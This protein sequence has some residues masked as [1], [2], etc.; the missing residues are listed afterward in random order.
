MTQFVTGYI[1][2][3]VCMYVAVPQVHVVPVNWYHLHGNTGLS[4]SKDQ[5]VELNDI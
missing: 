2:V 4:K 1:N 3:H 5:M